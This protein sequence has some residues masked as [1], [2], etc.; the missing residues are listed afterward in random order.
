MRSSAL[1][2]PDAP[3]GTVESV[4]IRGTVK[5]FNVVKGYG[6]LTPDDGSA[7]VFLHLTV[8]RV[9]IG[10]F[11][12]NVKRV[13]IKLRDLSINEKSPSRVALLEVV[14]G[15]NLVLTLRLHCKT[16]FGVQ[17][18]KLTVHFELGRIELVDLLVDGDG[19]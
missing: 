11:D 3:P 15:E 10:E 8:L 6:F 17:F 7:D 2:E 1:S 18:G 9:E 12:M 5:W 16:L 13:R 14:I 4:Q 19:F